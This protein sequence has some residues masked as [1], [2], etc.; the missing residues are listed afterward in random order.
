[1]G[2][3]FREPHG[4]LIY[5]YLPKWG[6]AMIAMIPIIAHLSFPYY[7]SLVIFII[8]LQ[9]LLYPVEFVRNELAVG[10]HHFLAIFQTWIWRFGPDSKSWIFLPDPDLPI[11]I[12]W[13]MWHVEDTWQQ[14]TINHD[15]GNPGWWPEPKGNP[16][17]PHH[18]NVE[19]IRITINEKGFSQDFSS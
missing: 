12:W 5:S 15:T 17:N 10:H 13:G 3:K 8:H 4:A 19:V 2:A 6:I 16:H 1:M 14:V 9:Q 18:A 11:S 7:H